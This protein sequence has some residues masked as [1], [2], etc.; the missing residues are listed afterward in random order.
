MIK[1]DRV[2]IGCISLFCNAGDDVAQV[3]GARQAHALCVAD[4]ALRGLSVN[5]GKSGH[6]MNWATS[7]LGVSPKSNWVGPNCEISE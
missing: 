6:L 4:T 1:R 3:R 7:H 5:K 2:A